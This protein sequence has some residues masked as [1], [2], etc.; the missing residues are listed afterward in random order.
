MAEGHNNLPDVAIAGGGFVGLG[1]ALALA[2][3]GICAVVIEAKS[4]EAY[5][6]SEA[7][8]DDRSLVVNPVSLAF[9]QQLGVWPHLAHQATA[10][11][12]VHVSHQGR[13]GVVDFSAQEQGVEQLGFVVSAQQLAS[14]LWQ[15][16]NNHPLIQVRSNTT[17]QSLTINDQHAVVDLSTGESMSTRLLV[18]ADG[19]QSA[20]RS[21]MGMATRT[22]DYQKTA[23]ISH[24]QMTNIRRQTA[25][26]RLTTNGPLALLPT[27]GQRWGLV[28]SVDQAS[29]EDMLDVDDE[30]FIQRLE[31]ALGPKLGQVT[32]LGRRS[33]YPIHQLK[34]EKQVSDRCVLLGNAA[35]AVSPVA[36]QG[37]NL[38]VRGIKRLVEH[39]AQSHHSE[40][41]LG[42]Q[43][44]LQRYQE[45]SLLDQDRTLNHTDD[46]MRWFALDTPIADG[47]KAG[48]MW[49]VNA[50]PA[51]K[52]RLF[53]RAGGFQS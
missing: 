26:E 15:M 1:C 31:Q 12:H 45:A 28:W 48:G 27:S 23:L 17:V 25:Y 53:L 32:R 52:R 18:A 49:A 47:L 42:A 19:V 3:V 13:W 44:T 39:L 41:D 43:T 8:F 10:I 50:I 20:I 36:A 6:P 37:L 11:D 35:H 16:A 38:A 2:Q 34:V 9:W 21:Q 30:T 33:S 40:Q 4:P 29:A 51:L 7:S 5:L 14:Q 46:L 24:V 22:K